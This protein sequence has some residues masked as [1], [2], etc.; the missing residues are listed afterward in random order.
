MINIPP[1]SASEAYSSGT[2]SKEEVAPQSS[3]SY[4]NDP[5]YPDLE[6]E[7]LNETNIMVADPPSPTHSLV[8]RPSRRSR[9]EGDDEVMEESVDETIDV[10]RG[11]SDDEEEGEEEG[12]VDGELIEDQEE[13]E[14]EIKEP[15]QLLVVSEMKEEFPTTLGN[16]TQNDVDGL[17]QDEEVWSLT[18]EE[19]E[20]IE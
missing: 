15:I 1:L 10:N 3:T 7:E 6:L 19:A 18:K 20:D 4:K 11:P 12:E 14:G 2:T 9:K 13:E 17:R 8:S 16:E 5:T